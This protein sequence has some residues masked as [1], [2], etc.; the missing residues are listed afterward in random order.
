M[1]NQNL[2]KD[3]LDTL[4]GESDEHLIERFNREVGN[5]GWTSTRGAYLAAIHAEFDR[6]DFDYSLIG[7]EQAL[8]YRYLVRLEVKRVVPWWN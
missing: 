7:N 8:S 5:R 4:A 1:T 6:R 3:F 2:F